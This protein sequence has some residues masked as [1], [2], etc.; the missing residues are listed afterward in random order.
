MEDLNSL[1]LQPGALRALACMAEAFPTCAMEF[2]QTRIAVE[3]W[4]QQYHMVCSMLDIALM[5]GEV[6][7]AWQLASHGVPLIQF[8][9][10]D[11]IMYRNY[12]LANFETSPSRWKR[13]RTDEQGL[14]VF[15]RI[16]H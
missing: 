10:T 11:V 8:D 5:R 4:D 3:G 14:P 1:A 12:T 7:A 9:V 15:F 2:S 13:S 6:E 16:V